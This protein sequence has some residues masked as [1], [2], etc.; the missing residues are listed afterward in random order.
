[1]NPEVEGLI[2]ALRDTPRVA[3]SLHRDYLVVQFEIP[4]GA[5]GRPVDLLEDRAAD[6]LREMLE[7]ARAQRRPNCPPPQG[8]LTMAKTRNL[9]AAYIGDGYLYGASGYWG[10]DTP[11]YWPGVRDEEGFALV[12]LKDVPL[13][14]AERLCAQGVQGEQCYSD[15]YEAARAA[16][17]YVAGVI[18]GEPSLQIVRRS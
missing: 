8:G 14:I 4:G 18:Y 1:M 5:L 11:R 12:E 13:E 9:I 15:G 7:A 3:M 10:A 6:S 2:L 17:P 16:A